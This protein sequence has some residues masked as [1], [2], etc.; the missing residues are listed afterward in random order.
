MDDDLDW[1]LKTDGIVRNVAK[2][3]S[4]RENATFLKEITGVHGCV[5][6]YF[7]AWKPANYCNNLRE[8]QKNGARLGGKTSQV[9]LQRMGVDAI[10]FT[11]DVLKALQHEG[12]VNRIPGSNKDWISLQAAIDT[13]RSKSDRSLTEMS[14][15][16][17]F[18]VD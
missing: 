12:I 9:F 3:R 17:A 7:A 5:G 18:S 1:L 4:L 14:Q 15:I 16:L 11:P 6:D 2:I 8:L 10:A 13:W